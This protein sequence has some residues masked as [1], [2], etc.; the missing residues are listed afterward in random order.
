ME[1]SGVVLCVMSF[2]VVWCGV[3]CVGFWWCVGSV[4][5]YGVVWCGGLRCN[6]KV[7][8]CVW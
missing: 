6:E 3:V 5:V 1:W 7:K 8:C 2:G 4:V